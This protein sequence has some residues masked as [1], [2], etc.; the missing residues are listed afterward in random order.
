MRFRAVGLACN[1]SSALNRFVTPILGSNSSAFWYNVIRRQ[2]VR[3]SATAV[4]LVPTMGGAPYRDASAAGRMCFLNH[5]TMRR[6]LSVRLPL[7][8]WSSF[9]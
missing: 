2:R 6:L 9:A 8:A 4:C 3:K 1:R 7:M 5:S